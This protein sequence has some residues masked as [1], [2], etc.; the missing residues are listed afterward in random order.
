MTQ[1]P[2]PTTPLCDLAAII[3]SKNAGPYRITLDILFSD[4]EAFE[5]VRDSG[6][7]SRAS[8]A[9]AYGIAEEAISSIYE[10]EMARA[11]KITLYRPV[12]QGDSGE[13]DLYGCQ[14]HVPLLTLPVSA[15]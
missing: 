10:I 15:P 11:F 5:T 14:Q 4:P 3:R 6:A 12:A 9:N 7:I 1:N 8:V 2:S 13:S